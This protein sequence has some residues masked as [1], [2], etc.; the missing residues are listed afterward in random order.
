MEQNI[1]DILYVTS[2]ILAE[3]NE[4]RGRMNNK[5]FLNQTMRYFLGKSIFL[6]FLLVFVGC[7][8]AKPTEPRGTWYEFKT[9]DTL[10]S[11]SKRFAVNPLIIQEEN[12]IYDPGDL[13][14]GMKIFLPGVQSIK[15][16]EKNK[17]SSSTVPVHKITIKAPPGDIKVRKNVK[18]RV[19]KKK[20]YTSGKRSMIWPSP[21][22]ISS[23]Y[24]RRHGRMHQGIDLTR[25][26]GRDILAAASGTVVYSGYKNGYGKCIIINHGRGLRTLYGHNKTNYVRKGQRVRQ[27][28]VIAKMGK[29]GRVTGIH[30]HFEIQVNGKHQNP[31]RYLPTR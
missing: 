16:T 24:G 22:I 20:R 15:T 21:G 7:S 19:K 29:T 5:F 6:M 17:L 23:G 4:K 28:S 30:L 2:I 11:V 26:G 14:A 10:E 13:A 31:L 8:G 18:Q 9:G 25:D 27:G 12:E 3:L 1:A